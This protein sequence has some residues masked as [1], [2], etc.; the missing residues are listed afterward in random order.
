MPRPV[1]PPIAVSRDSAA[2]GPPVAATRQ[3]SPSFERPPPSPLEPASPARPRSANSIPE[4]LK[5][6]EATRN[7]NPVDG[8]MPATVGDTYDAI[9]TGYQT[10]ERPSPSP[11][12][13]KTDWLYLKDKGVEFLF[14][15]SDRIS[16]IHF[17]APWSGSIRGVR[18]G[19]TVER[20][21]SLLGEPQESD[22]RFGGDT[23]A[24][25]YRWPYTLPIVFHGDRSSNKIKIIV[26]N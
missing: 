23:L 21:K 2:P 15:T 24:L 25:T 11:W 3:S 20:I 10:Y 12:D 7:K 13:K 19:D 26:L 16:S 18:L 14:D 9:V 17:V 4:Q 1:E 6:G 5:N 22:E 8:G